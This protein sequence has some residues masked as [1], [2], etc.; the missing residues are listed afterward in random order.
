MRLTVKLTIGLVLAILP[1]IAV[2][3][4]IR[5]S[6]EIAAADTDSR[7]DDVQLARTVAGATAA[8]WRTAGEREARLMV[9]GTQQPARAAAIRWTWPDAPPGTRDAP[10]IDALAL[11]N[12]A[13]GAPVIVDAD[14]VTYTYVGVATP[15]GRR[16]ALEVA[17]PDAPEDRFVR[18]TI[19]HAAVATGAVVALCGCLA[20]GL[21]AVF[22][23]RPVR[24]L[25]AQ[26]RK[27]G[28]GDLTTRVH[29]PNRDELGHLGAEI[30]AMSD[31]LAAATAARTTALEQV[32]RAD[33]LSTV[34]KL[35]AGIAHE[36]GTPLNV[37][38]GHAQLITCDHA[39]GTPEYEH[40]TIV[41]DQTQRVAKIIRQLLDFARRGTPDRVTAEL[42]PIV[43]D[44]ANLL[45]P[46]AE[47]RRATLVVELPDEPV[48]CLVDAGQIQQAL[49]NLVMN[50]LQ[51]LGD[52]KRVTL[53]LSRYRYRDVDYARIEVIDNGSG[54]TA[55]VLPHI[56]EPFF[57]TKAVGD[58]TGLGLSVTY[59]IVR[60]HDGWIDV[61]SQ[62]G[63][64]SEFSMVLPL[65]TSA[66]KVMS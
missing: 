57:T 43:T 54:I 37:I 42:G 23:G 38:S 25:V 10:A 2:N 59:G 21:G 28:A 53:R 64:G 32:R 12:L 34:G 58:G 6:R 56:F 46:L 49:T 13:S 19:R 20:L 7:T 16:G 62:V 41:V 22:V 47:G 14:G 18:L 4:G 48:S 51:A 33:R 45:R 15:S 29:L 50:G 40:A 5:V 8:V 60:D 9:T 26:T 39:E 63:V 55:A 66:R 44:T 31:Q 24:A 17:R 1:V 11:A 61:N 35:A 52:D 27:I 36:L 3:S 30:N 65:P